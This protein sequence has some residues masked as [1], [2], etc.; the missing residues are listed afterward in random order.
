MVTILN[1]KNPQAAF[2]LVTPQ[3]A[4][5]RRSQVNPGIAQVRQEIIQYAVD[6][7]LA[8]YDWYRASGGE[9][10]ASSWSEHA[11]LSRD[12]IHL[13]KDG[14]EYQGNLFYHALMKGYNS[15]VPNR[16]P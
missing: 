2:V 15:Y 13:T 4:F 11:L 12:G 10:S 7:G 3:D 14:Y 6:N 8:F 9:N 1:E 5:R 16:H